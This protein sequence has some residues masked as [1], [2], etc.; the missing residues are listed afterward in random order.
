MEGRL[1]DIARRFEIYLEERIDDATHVKVKRIER[2]YGGASRETY[3]LNVQYTTNGHATE[4]GMILR[5]DPTGSLIDT[6]RT[7]EFSAYRAFEGTRVPVPRALFLET[8]ERWL[9]RPFMVM[10]EIRNCQAAS[11]FNERPFAEV[12]NDAHE[13]LGEQFWKILGE[14]ARA[15]PKKLGLTDTFDVPPLDRCW[16]RELDYWEGVIDEDELEPQPIVRA[17]IRRLRREPPPA[18]QK[19]SVVHGDYRTGNFL[20]D[21]SAT[22]RAILDWEMSHLG[23]PL[24]DVAWAM[25]RLWDWPGGD[26]PGRMITRNRAIKTWEAASGLK[27][28]RQAFAWWELFACVKGMAIWISSSREYHDSDKKEPVLGYSGMRCADMHN[29]IIIDML[30]P[31]MENAS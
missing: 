30:S 18:A 13:K 9:D 15:D 20:F 3:R 24:E 2:I 28:D 7:T 6:D 21:S 1:D 19:L 12:G 31:A 11:P 22:V 16:M 23:D 5:R 25:T 10:E 26:T 4:K 29:R 27:I 17:A 14:I 8:D